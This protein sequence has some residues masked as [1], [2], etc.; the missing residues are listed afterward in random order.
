[1]KIKIF[2]LITTFFF[3]FCT[4]TFASPTLQKNSRGD[5]VIALQQ[6]LY[7]IGY[8]ITEIDGILGMRPSEQLQHFNTT[9]K[10][11]LQELLQMSLGEL[12]KK[13]NPIKVV[14]SRLLKKII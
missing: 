13:Q 12:F 10:S 4:T 9:I 11:A 1:M 6:K 5:D 3:I 8:N 2:A 7:L 14:H